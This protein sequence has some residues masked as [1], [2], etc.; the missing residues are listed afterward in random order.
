MCPG[1]SNPSLG[2][3]RAVTPVRSLVKRRRR[4]AHSRSCTACSP[5]VHRPPSHKKNMHQLRFGQ[6]GLE[7]GAFCEYF[8][9]QRCS[10]LLPVKTS[11]FLHLPDLSH[12]LHDFCWKGCPTDHGR[13]KC[14]HVGGFTCCPPM[15]KAGQLFVK[16]FL[17]IPS[18]T[19]S[20]Q[21]LPDKSTFLIAKQW[22]CCSWSSLKIS[23]NFKREILWQWVNNNNMSSEGGEKS[24]ESWNYFSF[25]TLQQIPKTIF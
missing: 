7:F 11:C 5:G 8:V 10:S 1:T 17:V 23:V 2:V 14:Q 6:V 15:C 13:T 9:Q 22:N 24:V 3:F 20:S 4:Q 25:S 18:L 21:W 16:I 19:F 12:P